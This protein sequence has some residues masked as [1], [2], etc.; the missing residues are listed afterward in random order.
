MQHV[1]LNLINEKVVL[2]KSSD[3][4][5][6]DVMFFLFKQE[7]YEKRF[8][9]LSTIDPY[10]LTIINELQTKSLIQDLEA[11]QIISENK[12]KSLIQESVNFIKESGDLE[13]IQFIGD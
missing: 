3:I 12:L 1:A 11:L 2:I 7:D 13:F 6:A 4:N 10:G 8:P 5:F 9:W